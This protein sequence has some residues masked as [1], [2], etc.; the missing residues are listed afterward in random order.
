MPK[1]FLTISQKISNFENFQFPTSHMEA[2]NP[3]GLVLLV[4]LQRLNEFQISRQKYI[5]F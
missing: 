1:N 5:F 4:K 2:E 3:F